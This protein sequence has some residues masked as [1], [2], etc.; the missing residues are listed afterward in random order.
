M[1]IIFCISDFNKENIYLQPWLTFHRVAVELIEKGY[2]VHIITDSDQNNFAPNIIIHNVVSLKGTN[3]K[4]I[5]SLV[6]SISPQCIIL[7]VTPFSLVTAGWYEFLTR[8]KSIAI[9]SYPFYSF[10]QIFRALPYLNSREIWAYCRHVL[11]PE[12]LWRSRLLKY[13]N[14][15]VCQSRNTKRKLEKITDSKIS[16]Q[17]I[18]PGIDKKIWY[19]DSQPTNSTREPTFL[20]LG[21]PKKI[22]GYNLILDAF[23]KISADCK[24]K[25]KILARGADDCTL[26]ILQRDIF[27][28]KLEGCVTVKGG[29]LDQKTIKQEIMLSVAVLLPFVLVPSEMP[30]AIM[31]SIFCGTPVIISDVDG[32]SEMAGG[33]GIVIPQANTHELALA[34]KRLADN[35]D[36]VTKLRKEC[37]NAGDRMLT[38]KSVSNKWHAIIAS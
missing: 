16:I 1:R 7:T 20:Y 10:I 12:Y 33:A 30:V 35:S 34:V 27:Q 19:N 23:Q 8:Y 32:L 5:N 21:S 14:A 6:T 37:A 9:V 22:R 4:A 26:N 11:V 31:E 2:E 15:V 28:R 38:W 25:L 36:L 3:T 29:W 17:M 18:P 24:A 13:F